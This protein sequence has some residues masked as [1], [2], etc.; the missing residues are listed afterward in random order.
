[1]LN[2]AGI[3]QSCILTGAAALM[4]GDRFSVG[5]RYC[6]LLHSVRTGSGAHPA[7]YPVVAGTFFPGGDVDVLDSFPGRN[8]EFSSPL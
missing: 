1:V 8:R 6:S 3:A 5:E 2:N 4:A 7:T